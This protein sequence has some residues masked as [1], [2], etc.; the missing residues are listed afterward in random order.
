MKENAPK[1][2]VGDLVEVVTRRAG[3]VVCRV[4]HINDG[5]ARFSLSPV[6]HGG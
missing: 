5:K 1:L 4:V 6:K 3:T 2:M